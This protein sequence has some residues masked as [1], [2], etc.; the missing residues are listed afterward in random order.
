MPEPAVLQDFSC[1]Q[2]KV[3]N[4]NEKAKVMVGRCQRV[5]KPEV[6]L[7]HPYHKPTYV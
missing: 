2:M 6:H 1:Q 5:K 4:K 7:G 3:Q